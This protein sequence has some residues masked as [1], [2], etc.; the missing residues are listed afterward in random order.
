MECGGAAAALGWERRR[1]SNALHRRAQSSRRPAHSGIAPRA[2]LPPQSG[3]CAAALQILMEITRSI[4]ADGRVR[5]GLCGRLDATWSGAVQ[6]ALAECIRNGQHEIELDLAEVPFL[7]S[8][9]I[10]VLLV[11]HRQLHGIHG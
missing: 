5:L 8:A 6:D 4:V 10:R 3:G 1:G 7:S 9:G 2:P 11:T